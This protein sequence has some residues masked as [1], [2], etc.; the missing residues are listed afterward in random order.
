LP[1]AFQALNQY[2]DVVLRRNHPCNAMK[3]CPRCQKTYADDNLN[4]CFEDGSTLQMAPAE[5]L[6]DTIVMNEPARTEATQ[7]ML[8]RQPPSQSAWQQ[9]QSSP[10]P[11]SVQPPAKGSSKTWLWVVG[12]IGVL[13]LLCGGGFVGLIFWAAS[14]ADKTG[15]SIFNVNRASRADTV[16][17]TPSK[18][19]STASTSASGRTELTTVDLEMFTKSFSVF[20]TTTLNGDELEMGSTMKDYYYVL[21]APDKDSNDDPVDEF[22]T[23]DADLRVTVRNIEGGDTRFGYGLVF[24]SDPQPLQQ[25]YAF[26]IDAKKKRYRVVRH[27]PEKELAVVKWTASPAIKGGTEENILEARD[28]PDKIE[29]YINGTMVTSIPN[30]Y[31]YYGGVIGVYSGGAVKTGFKNLEIRR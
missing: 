2:N 17:T 21:A 20:A 19:T 29:L 16:Q 8:P 7:P 24:H 3:I 15:N 12:I 18:T 27:Q 31:G 22:K 9:Q 11:V 25:G 13:I 30:K 5:V 10:Q 26:L 4:F 1:V 23:S 6:P 14:H 28:H